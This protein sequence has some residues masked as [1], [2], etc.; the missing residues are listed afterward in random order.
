LQQSVRPAGRA[1]PVLSITAIEA[2][3][4]ALCTLGLLLRDFLTT[5]GVP[6]PAAFCLP[7]RLAL[8]AAGQ[9]MAKDYNGA[10]VIAAYFA[11]LADRPGAV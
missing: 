10:A 3:A 4:G 1:A 8:F 6:P 11:V 2:V 9:R 5:A 7:P